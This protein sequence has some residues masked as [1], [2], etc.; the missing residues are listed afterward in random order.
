MKTFFKDGS[1]NLKAS[2]IL[3]ME[4]G[5]SG[6]NGIQPIPQEFFDEAAKAADKYALQ[7]WEQAEAQKNFANTEINVSNEGTIETREREKSS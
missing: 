6:A 2:L 5:W 3:L 4:H 7:E 1:R